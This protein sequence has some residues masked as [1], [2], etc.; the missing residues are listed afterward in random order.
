[1]NRDFQRD[2]DLLNGED[3][4]LSFG[5]RPSTLLTDLP[6]RDDNYFRVGLVNTNPYYL[7]PYFGKKDRLE[8]EKP[9]ALL[10]GSV[11]PSN[12]HGK[13]CKGPETCSC[14]IE[15]QMKQEGFGSP[16]QEPK[17]EPSSSKPEAKIDQDILNAMKSATVNTSRIS[18]KQRFAKSSNSPGEVDNAK[19]RKIDMK[20][21]FRFVN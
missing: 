18:V 17:V 1:M 20:D 8:I 16:S 9:I 21:K 15:K 13:D 3:D 5:Q 12:P 14:L 6:G 10:P 11:A 4:N 19:K 7:E 2:F